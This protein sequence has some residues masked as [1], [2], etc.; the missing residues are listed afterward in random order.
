MAADA[1]ISWTTP[2]IFCPLLIPNAANHNEPRE[3]RT[4]DAVLAVPRLKHVSDTVPQN[5]LKL[6][7]GV[8]MSDFV[9]FQLP[10]SSNIEGEFAR[11]L[12]IFGF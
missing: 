7:R 11:K 6:M 10:I 4:R 5:N 12:L 8:E 9:H 3:R 2:R 1:T